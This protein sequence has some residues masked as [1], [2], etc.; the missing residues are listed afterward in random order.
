MYMPHSI[1]DNI[2]EIHGAHVLNMQK[3]SPL[4]TE[5]F[6]IEKDRKTQRKLQK[7]NRK[8]DATPCNCFPLTIG[9]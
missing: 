8:G 2:Q 7:N 5:P 4:T 1:P 9:I 6:K 3:R